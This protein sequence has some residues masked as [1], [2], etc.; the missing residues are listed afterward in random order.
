MFLNNR[1]R[2]F[3]KLY[4]AKHFYTDDSKRFEFYYRKNWLD[5]FDISVY[6]ITQKTN[7]WFMITAPVFVTMVGIDKD[8]V[9]KIYKKNIEKSP[10]PKAANDLLHNHQ[11]KLL[12]HK[13]AKF[14]GETVVC[15]V[16]EFG[17][18]DERKKVLLLKRFAFVPE[19]DNLLLGVDTM[20]LPFDG[21]KAFVKDVKKVFFKD[22][23]IELEISEEEKDAVNKN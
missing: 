23:D 4:S 6:D 2:L 9:V 1:K 13:I 5:Q 22:V 17:I 15:K 8:E 14:N 3:K 18:E 7:R 21:V 10:K 16:G 19:R 12:S 20:E 11:F